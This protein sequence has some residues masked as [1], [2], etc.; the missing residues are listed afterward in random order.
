M[1][2]KQWVAMEM[3]LEKVGRVFACTKLK[4]PY[5][6]GTPERA[7]FFRLLEER[8][9]VHVSNGWKDHSFVTYVVI[10]QNE[11]FMGVYSEG[12]YNK[13]DY[14]E[15]TLADLKANQITIK[16]NFVVSDFVPPITKAKTKRTKKVSKM[17][18]VIT[19]NTKPLQGG[20]LAEHVSS[21]AVVLINKDANCATQKGAVKVTVLGF[22]KR[23]KGNKDKVA[24]HSEYELSTL[25]PFNGD[26]ILTN[27][28]SI[29]KV[30]T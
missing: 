14:K 4:V 21:G 18:A 22:T 28:K 13:F 9:I 5:D 3:P 24:R 25:T 1:N 26:V 12:G 17:E 27:K 2:Y 10:D 30:T 29:K 23:G 7:G 20:D 19:E 8:G 16:P 11:R 6:F 15:I